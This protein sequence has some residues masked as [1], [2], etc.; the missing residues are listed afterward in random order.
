MSGL[1]Y[2]YFMKHF[3]ICCNHKIPNSVQV[4]DKLFEI[5]ANSDVSTEVLD[6]DELE[7]GFDFVFVIGGD[8]TILKTARFYAKTKTPVFGVNLGRLGFLSQSSEQELDTAV[9]KILD[10]KFVLQDRIMLKSGEYTALNDFVIKS[11]DLGRTA[12][13]SLM[14]NDKFVCDYL[15][16]GIIISTP[17]GS[18]AYGLSAGGPVLHPSLSAF[19]IVPICPHTLTARPIVVPDSEKLTVCTDGKTLLS[20]DG[21]EFYEF[22]NRISVEKSDFN[23]E[24]ALIEGTEFYSVLKNKLHWATP[25]TY[26]EHAKF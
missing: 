17:T 12:K 13:F 4:K 26:M 6:I 9:R 25:P 16:D 15:A 23:A 24:L 5:L 7:G 14:I 10:G 20:A 21:Q 1:C 3:A 22:D 18:T 8:G 2:I 11:C 19:V